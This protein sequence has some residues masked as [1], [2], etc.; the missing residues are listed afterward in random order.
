MVVG[1]RFEQGQH[2]LVLVGLGTLQS[3]V[4]PAEQRRRIGHRAVQPEL[5][6][7]I[8]EVVMGTDISP[9]APTAVSIQHMTDTVQGA[10]QGVARKQAFQSGLVTRPKLD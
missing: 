2:T 5:V 8:T 10:K 7:P 9:A 4:I 6:E 3:L 1:F